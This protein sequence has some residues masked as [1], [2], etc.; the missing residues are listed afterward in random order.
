MLK[1]SGIIPI[2]ELKPMTE[3]A[4]FPFGKKEQ[5]AARYNAGVTRVFHELGTMVMIYQKRT[6]KM[7]ARWRGPF[8]ITG[9][10]GVH[11][12]NWEVSQLNGRKI[13]GT[14]HGDHLMPFYERTGYLAT[15]ETFQPWQTVRRKRVVKG[16]KW[17]NEASRSSSKEI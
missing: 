3:P 16:R 15:E 7:E 4:N 10:G 1:R 17:G 8:W 12:L 5:G 9:Y 6:T 11:G 2:I 13:Q 14:F